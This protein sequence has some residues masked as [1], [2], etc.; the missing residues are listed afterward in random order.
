MA[1]PRVALVTCATLPEPDPD[2][3]IL[4]DAL[5]GAGMEAR[6]LAWDAPPGHPKHADPSDFHI[7]VLRSCWNYYE[8]PD[9]FLAWADRAAASSR[10]LNPAPVVRW[11]AHKGY[12]RR[13]ARA[14]LPVVPTVYADK[15]SRASF[16]DILRANKWEDAVVKPCVSA[17][18]FMTRRFGAGDAIEAQRFLDEL[19]RSRDAMIQPYMRSVDDSGERSIMW[20]SGGG[21]GG[22]GE[23]THAIRKS[24]RFAGQE[25]S[26]S[27]SLPASDNERDLFER[28]L[29]AVPFA[30]GELLYARLD[31]MP[32]ARGDMLISELELIEPSL[33]L[34]Q[35][36]RA[37]RSFVRAVAARLR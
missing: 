15:G 36:P 23:A 4:L 2:E 24:P 11:N 14:G 37:L 32:D 31:L 20:I 29:D 6:L 26:V 10:L 1:A 25:E 33:F 9:D 18:S 17:A 22:G 7:C 8:Q 19:M 16:A 3:T 5:N 27:G 21:G 34:L 13:L 30:K 12:L 35:E 28:T